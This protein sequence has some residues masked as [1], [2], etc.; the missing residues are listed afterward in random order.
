MSWINPDI[1]YDSLILK[2]EIKQENRTID[3]SLTYNQTLYTITNLKPG[4]I[5][6]I[7][8]S[9]IVNNTELAVSDS[10]NIISCKYW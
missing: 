4:S 9:T 7:T 1:Y 5:L 2:Y 6:L 8:I 10:I 3:K